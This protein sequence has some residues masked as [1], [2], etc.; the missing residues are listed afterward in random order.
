MKVPAAPGDP[1]TVRL[2]VSSTARESS[3]GVHAR[4]TP[5]VQLHLGTGWGWHYW[6]K[7]VPVSKDWVTFPGVRPPQ[8]PLVTGSFQPWYSK[9]VGLPKELV[10]K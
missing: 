4:K 10:L 9:T 3:S 7:L 1:D 6:I 5:G 2:G 8:E